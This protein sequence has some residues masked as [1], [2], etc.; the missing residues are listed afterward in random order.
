MGGRNNVNIAV[1]GPN[2]FL[3]WHLRCAVR[4]LHDCDVTL[5]GRPEFEDRERM[6]KAL[7]GVDAVIHLAGLNRGASDDEIERVNVELAET[8][9]RSIAESGRGIP[10]VFA[11]SVHVD[12]DSAFGRSKA[13]AAEVLRQ[14]TGGPV[15]DVILPNIFGEHGRPDYNSFV[16]TFCSVIAN[17]QTPHI[18]EDRDINLLHAQDAAESLLS[19][20]VSASEG[21]TRIDGTA[22]TVRSV[23]T[24][25]EAIADGYR[26]GQ[27]PD[28][29]DKF[30]QDLFNTY[31]SF[32]F[33]DQF[34]VYPDAM[35]D[36]RGR[37]VEGVRAFGGQA[38][39]FFS[40]TKPGQTRGEHFHLRK[41]ERFIVL[42]G[43][44]DIQL[45]RLF[46]DEVV[47]FRVSGL[48]PAIIDMPTMWAHSITNVGDQDLLTLFYADQVFN[49]QSPDTYREQV[50]PA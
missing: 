43:T 21:E 47:T 19:L 38:Q 39:V 35:S 6:A 42:Q 40:S 45:R 30:T 11:N 23:L 50:V 32:T 44:A 13:Q 18:V 31:R 17:G 4:A 25:L 49:P 28:L 3:A 2:G 33:P 15:A 1:T 5:I 20:A 26:T 46:T 7:E 48:K 36:P 8:L 37:L 9:A 10:V 41:V 34:P 27:L 22:T 16:A 12:G 24:Q 29:G 14:Q